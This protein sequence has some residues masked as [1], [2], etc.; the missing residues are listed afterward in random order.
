MA[1]FLLIH[2]AWHGGWCW[3]K[4]VPLL[5]AGGHRA[6]APDLPGHGGDKTPTASVTLKSYADRA[7]E[8]AAKQSEPVILVGHS[9]GGVVITQ[10][11]ENCPGNIRAL[12]YLC[13]F[14]PRN[15]DSLATWASLDPATMVNPSTLDLRP[16]GSSVFK[17]QSA[18]EAFYLQ[19]S[20][21]DV[22]FAQSR[23][24]P[25]AAAP[26]TTPVVTTPERW[27]RVPRYYIECSRDRALMPAVQRAMQK[28]LPCRQTFSIETDHSPF[29]S[30]PDQLAGI[31]DR[32]AGL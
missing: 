12:V 2:G 28:E 14:L 29:F 30:A 6:L 32:I 10:A 21:D 5:E 3:R 31:L 17:P 4:A 8:V 9:M 18:R 23:L 1:T 7:C 26:T 19:C 20:D 25:Q 16:D 24:V 15:G 11:A 22:A 27:G 13:A